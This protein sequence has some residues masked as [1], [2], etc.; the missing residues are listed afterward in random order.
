MATK[1]LA[2]EAKFHGGGVG[3]VVAGGRSLAQQLA[4]RASLAASPGVLSGAGK[5]WSADAGAAPC[6]SVDAWM[7][8]WVD[9]VCMYVCMHV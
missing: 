6:T 7:D 4:A 1:N 8:G 5:L 9:G 3:G 2:L